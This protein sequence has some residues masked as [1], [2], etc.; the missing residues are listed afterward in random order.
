MVRVA[1]VTLAKA[2]RKKPNARVVQSRQAVTRVK[3]MAKSHGNGQNLDYVTRKI[4]HMER[5]GIMQDPNQRT[6]A[7]P[8]WRNDEH[9][10]INARVDRHMNNARKERNV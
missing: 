7:R 6:T 1:S 5:M 3:M 10:A 9:K 4:V 8:A 2:Q